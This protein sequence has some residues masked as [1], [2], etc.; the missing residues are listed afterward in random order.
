MLAHLLLQ[1]LM[2]NYVPDRKRAYLKANK[3]NK[4]VLLE[5]MPGL[6]QYLNDKPKLF[7]QL[8]K[9]EKKLEVK[10]G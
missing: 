5:H 4:D 7:V 9:D 3:L 8:Y 6:P 1:V 2:S 10:Y